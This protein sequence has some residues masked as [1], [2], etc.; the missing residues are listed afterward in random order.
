MAAL[1][2]AVDTLDSFRLDQDSD[3]QVSRIAAAFEAPFYG[4]EARQGRSAIA[5]VLIDEASLD[6]LGWETPVPYAAQAELVSTIA[7]YAPAAIFMDFSYRRPHGE[8]PEREVANMGQVLEGV[9]ETEGV[10]IFLG[11]VSNVS[12]FAPLTQF[13]S[14]DVEWVS[15][16]ALDYPLSWE[17]RPLAAAALYDVYCRSREDACARGQIRDRDAVLRLR[18]GYG[19]SREMRAFTA[20][21]APCATEGADAA[22]KVLAGIRIALAAAARAVYFQPES[23]VDPADTTCVYL[24]HISAAQALDPRFDASLADLLHDRIVLVGASH[25]DT[26]DRHLIPGV[27][28]I[29][30]VFIHAT[31]LDN[32]ITDG[33]D[34]V[35]PPPTLFAALDWSDAI[36]YLLTIG[37]IVVF[38]ATKGDRRLGA[39]IA[40]STIVLIGLSFWAGVIMRWPA[41]N[42]LGI[43]AIW[44]AAWFSEG[45]EMKRIEQV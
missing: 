22:E 8:A 30:G 4:G 25:L 40:V 2:L 24:D 12:A 33:D 17:G 18:F 1:L 36:E 7:N 44:I 9:R 5:V 29:P 15:Q 35:R 37:L 34:Y 26:A 20:A 32:L 43:A 45:P 10:P 27:G 14:L 23:K 42:V 13:P 16:S 39:R 6:I 28:R 31:A 21:G 19:A 41:P 3:E 11:P 38:A